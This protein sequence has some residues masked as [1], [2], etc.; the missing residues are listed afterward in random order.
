MRE[1]TERATDRF[2]IFVDGLGLVRFEDCRLV[3]VDVE[4]LSTV[5]SARSRG[6]PKLSI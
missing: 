3:G 4:R 2:Q 1:M 6:D 5:Q